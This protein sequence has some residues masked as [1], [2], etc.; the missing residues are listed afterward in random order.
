ME[1]SG[2]AYI[3]TAEISLIGDGSY[4][5]SKNVINNSSRFNPRENETQ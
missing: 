1:N 4:D 2:G 5:L 3:T